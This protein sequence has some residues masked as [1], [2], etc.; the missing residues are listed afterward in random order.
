VTGSAAPPFSS[1]RR[2]H[3]MILLFAGLAIAGAL[4]PVSRAEW[5]E[6]N[7][8]IFAL[9]LLLVISFRWWHLSDLSYLLLLTF[10]L[11]ATLGSH[12]TYE[13]NRSGYG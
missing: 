5:W 4:S 6:G 7:I 1:R 8:P 2:L 12:Y 11:L 10:L 3:L 13:R 9:L